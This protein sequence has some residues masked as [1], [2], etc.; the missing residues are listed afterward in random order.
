MTRI[1]GER[2]RMLQWAEIEGFVVTPLR[3][4]VTL[5][6][7]EGRQ[8]ISIPRFLDDYRGCIA[9]IK[10]RGL[11]ILPPDNAQVKRVNRSGTTW[12]QALLSYAALFAFSLARDS[13]ESHALRLIALAACIGCFTW[14]ITDNIE[15][16]D[17]SW[18]RWISGSLLAGL[19]AWL[20]WHMMHTW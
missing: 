2:S 18:V 8:T 10:A 17:H 14:V 4:G 11:R 16:E 3:G 6:P 5:I 20:V 15:G 1:I 19:L 7:R 13:R 12:K 9:E